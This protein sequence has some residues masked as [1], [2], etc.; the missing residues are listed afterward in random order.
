MV[1]PSLTWLLSIEIAAWGPCNASPIRR[2]WSGLLLVCL[3]YPKKPL[4]DWAAFGEG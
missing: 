4:P 2:S 3:F 1:S